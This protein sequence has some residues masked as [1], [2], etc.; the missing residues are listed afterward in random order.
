MST[1]PLDNRNIN[2]LYNYGARVLLNAA[3]HPFEY[4]KVLI[5]IGHEPIS[6]TPTTTF[7]G[8][9][10]LKLPNIFEYV[11]YIKSVD[12]ITGCYRGIVPKVCGNIVGVITSDKI[13]RKYDKLE[14]QTDNNELDNREDSLETMDS[15]EKFIYN[16]KRDIVCRVSSI[17]VSHPFH[18]ITVRIMAQFV[19]SESAYS[20]LFGSIAEIYRQNG[21]MGFFSGLIPRVLGDVLYTVLAASLT[22]AL[23]TYVCQ[24]S[25]IQIY[26]S[27]TM[28]FLASAITYPFQVVSN[29]MAVTGSGLSAGAPPNMPHY[30]NWL[31][32]WFDLSQKGQLKRGSSLLIRYYAGPHLVIA[33]KPV[34]V[35]H[36]ISGN[37]STGGTKLKY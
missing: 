16:V 25:E 19:G 2:P 27:T 6:P 32:C 3:A 26:T 37:F 5:Q 31:D 14:R 20:G 30:T 9:S 10:A 13:L 29:C 34:P 23:N 17:I 33:G 11:K 7:L 35:P 4:A 1:K 12:G 36:G 8:K 22:Y 15:R 18:V 24:E 28:T 21:I